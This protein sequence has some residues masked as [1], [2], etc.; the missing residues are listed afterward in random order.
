MIHN[1]SMPTDVLIPVIAYPSVSEAVAWL[2][3]AFGFTL[4]WQVGTHR[5]QVGVG[6]TAAI[7]IVAGEVT[8]GA[9]HVMVRVEDIDAHR[10]RAEAAGARVTE[11]GEFPYGERQYTATDFAGRSWVFTESVADVAPSDW[12]ATTPERPGDPG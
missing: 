11:I 8:P 12:G 3:D 10:A 5:A 4:R 7:A 9:D 1:R 6:P 2:A